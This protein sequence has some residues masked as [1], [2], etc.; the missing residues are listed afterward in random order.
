[1]ITK[2]Y[3]EELLSKVGEGLTEKSSIDNLA[4]LKKDAEALIDENEK[5]TEKHI[6]LTKAYRESILGIDRKETK[7]PPKDN[8]PKLDEDGLPSVSQFLE[9]ITKG[10]N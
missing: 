8:A 4:Q 3:L 7:E 1:M 2:E 5:L 9:Q 10:N 6:E